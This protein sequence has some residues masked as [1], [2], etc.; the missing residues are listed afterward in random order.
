[1]LLVYAQG[2]LTVTTALQSLVVIVLLVDP[3]TCVDVTGASM[4]PYNLHTTWLG[5]SGVDSSSAISLLLPHVSVL[6]SV[7]VK[8]LIIINDTRL[9]AALL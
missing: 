4:P 7:P 8:W 2:E 5:V 9:L 6:L 3:V 1:M